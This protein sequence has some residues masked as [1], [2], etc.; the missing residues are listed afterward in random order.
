MAKVVIAS[1]NPV[2]INATIEAFSEAFKEFSFDYESK[3]VLS[4]VKSQPDSEDETLKGALNRIDN[5]TVEVPDADYWVA[6]E[7]G[8]SHIDNDILVFD[9]A[10]VR[11]SSLE[12]RGRSSSFF[13][14][15]K[16]VEVVK[17]GNGVGTSSDLVFGE[18]NLKQKNGV[19][20]VLSNNLFTRTSV[21]KDAVL[22]ALIPFMNK[23][24]Y[25]NK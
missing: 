25:L 4:G 7:G 17:K 24:L 8:I 1:T 6:I 5:L 12:G 11:S 18:T 10:V 23:E 15:Q 9:W 14:P 20:G 2:K 19:V 21:S 16:V 13:L 22:M 3:S